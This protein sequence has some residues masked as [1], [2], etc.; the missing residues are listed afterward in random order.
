MLL[1]TFVGQVR[2][3]LVRVIHL[4]QTGDVMKEDGMQEE[5]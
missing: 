2:F 4:E 1:R 3:S 5:I